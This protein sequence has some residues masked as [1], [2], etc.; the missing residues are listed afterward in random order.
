MPEKKKVVTSLNYASFGQRFLAAIVDVIVL[1]LIASL[2]RFMFGPRLYNSISFFVGAAYSIVLW[3]NWNGQTIGKKLLKIKVVAE[4]GKPVDYRT[5]ILRYIGYIVSAVPLLI[6]F[7]WVLWDE[8][9]Q[10]WQDK[11][12]KTYVVN[13]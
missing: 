10:A 7:F 2:W 6:G 13:E 5:A 1:M 8:K 3:V 4:D 9:K 12:A 11:I